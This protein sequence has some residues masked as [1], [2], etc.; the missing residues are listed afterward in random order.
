MR[1]ALS[2]AGLTPDAVDYLNLHGT[3]TP[4]ND[5]AEDLAVCE[6]FGR[7]LRA[8]LDLLVRVQ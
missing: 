7:E 4:S 3:G 1:A 5:A 6:V 8:P 2:S